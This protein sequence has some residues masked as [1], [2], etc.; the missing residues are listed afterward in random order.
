[1]S[2]HARD[3]VEVE[4]GLGGDVDRALGHQ[5]VAPEV[6]VGRGCAS[7]RGA[8]IEARW[9]RAPAPRRCRRAERGVGQRRHAGDADRV[10]V[11]PSRARHE[12]AAAERGPPAAAEGRRATRRRPPTVRR[13]PG[14]RSPWP[15]PAPRGRSSWCRRPGRR[16]SGVR[17]CRPAP[18]LLAEDAVGGPLR[19]TRSRMHP[20]DRLVGVAHR[21]QVRLGL[22]HEVACVEAVHGDRVG[23]VRDA[24]REVEVVGERLAGHGSDAIGRVVNPKRACSVLGSGDVPVPPTPRTPR[25]RHDHEPALAPARGARG[26]RPDP[27]ELPGCRPRR[28]QG[29][30]EPAA[31]LPRAR[32]LVRRDGGGVRGQGER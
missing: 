23:G 10:A 28:R 21:G 22:H 16:S 25:V 30:V 19:R 27:A 9:R 15:R 14:A 32:L 5:Q 3:V 26:H 18:V 1:M 2:D 31:R 6:A 8:A 20:L 13:R 4:L 11:L 17:R 12:R 29:R 7:R 24:L